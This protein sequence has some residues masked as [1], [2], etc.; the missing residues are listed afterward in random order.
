L[1][2]MQA[3]LFRITYYPRYYAINFLIKLRIGKMKLKKVII[4][5]DI[6][7]S[8]EIVLENVHSENLPRIGERINLGF[9]PSPT[10]KEI[11]W[12]DIN[13]DVVLITFQ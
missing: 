11:I 10:I 13:F 1:A 3:R 2:G 4:Q 9:V 5:H 6:L 12:A 7:P 8:G